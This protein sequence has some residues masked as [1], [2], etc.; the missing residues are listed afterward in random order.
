V[1]RAA[2]EA[3]DGDYLALWAGQGVAAARALPA[4]TL[5]QELARE[6]QAA[7]RQMQG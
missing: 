5:V 7:R 2:A 1:R 3:D 4:A 6:W